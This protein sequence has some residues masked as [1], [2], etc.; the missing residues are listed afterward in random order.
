MNN[1]YRSRN[2]NRKKSPI[3]S[4]VVMAVILLLVAA[5]DASED[6]IMLFVALLCFLIPIA[7]IFGG[8][9][10]IRKLMKQAAAPDHSHD[11]IDHD[12]DI[13]INP[14]TGKAQSV[15]VQRRVQHSPQQHWKEQLDG[16][17]ANGTIDKAEYK[18]MMRRKF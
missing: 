15:P 11:R 14:A 5:G 1:R 2:E 10:Y 3:L 8:V 12:R 16:L 4:V 13:R 6:G 9:F 18:A 17:L 7:A